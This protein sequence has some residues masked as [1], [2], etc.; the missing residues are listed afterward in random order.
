MENDTDLRW[1][2]SQEVEALP[3]EGLTGPSAI[4]TESAVEVEVS[5]VYQGEEEKR[6]AEYCE[7]REA[8]S[9]GETQT[10]CM[11]ASR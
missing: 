2:G 3:R 9:V 7:A 11:P 6:A 10:A 4:P 8:V 5:K 1:G